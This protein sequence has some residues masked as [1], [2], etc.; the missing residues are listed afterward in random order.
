M[1]FFSP[2]PRTF[3]AKELWEKNGA[4]IMAV[5]RPGC[6]LCREVSTR[7][8]CAKERILA[9][10]AGT[11]PARTNVLEAPSDLRSAPL[12][13]LGISLDLFPV[14][15]HLTAHHIMEL[16]NTLDSGSLRPLCS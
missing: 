6:F 13:A 1:L 9:S 8:L 14:C 2:D 10:R 16:A 5:R 4:V 15:V 3:K 12:F 7:R 11:F